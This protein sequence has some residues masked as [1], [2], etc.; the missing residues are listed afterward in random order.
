MARR[1]SRRLFCPFLLCALLAYAASARA[2]A[3]VLVS[4]VSRMTH[5]AAG[6]FDV[7][8]PLVADGTGSGIEC[9]LIDSG[10]T[11]V[12]T[13]NQDVAASAS[14]ATAVSINGSG[15]A[16]VAGAP[17]FSTTTVS[18][19]LTGLAN[20]QTY[21]V[22]ITNVSAAGGLLPS[23]TVW[24]RTLYGDANGSG[25]VSAMDVA[26]VH[27]QEGVP[28]SGMNFRCDLNLN[29]SINSTDTMICRLKNTNTIA[30]GGTQNNPPTIASIPDQSA[31]A[32]VATT[33][34]GFSVSDSE[35][36]AGGLVVQA[37]SSDA[38]ILPTA[39]IAVTGTGASRSIVVTPNA[40]VIGS[41]TVTVTVS[42]GLTSRSAA[43]NVNVTAPSTLYIATLAPEHGHPSSGTG[44]ALLQVSG[45][46]T[47]AILR[48]QYS[49]LTSPKVAEHIHFGGPNV[50]G[51]IVYDIDTPA[52]PSPP[53]PLPDGSHVW[54][55]DPNGIPTP[56]QIV[57]DIA[58]GN[59]YMNVHTANYPDGEIRGQFY[60]ANGSQT[61]TPPAYV[62]PPPQSPITLNDASRF[63]QQ[64]TF[65]PTLSELNALSSSQS[66]TP[67]T[68]WLNQQFAMPTTTIYDVYK[69]RV[70]NE[71]NSQSPDRV[72]ESW[73]KNSLTAPDQ[74]RQRVAFAYSQ[75]FVVS[76]LDDAISGQPAGLAT[77]H[78]M[79][80]TDAFINFRT[81]LKD[82]TLHPI[83]GQYLNMRGNKKQTP[84]AV[85]NE[86]Y[87]REI[88]QLFSIGL[89]NLQPDGTL[90]LDQNGL[91]I[92]SYDQSVITAFSQVFTG[93]DVIASGSVPAVDTFQALTAV[94]PPATYATV[95]S[96]YHQPMIVTASNHSGLVKNLLSYS[97]NYTPSSPDRFVIA[98]N[99]SQTTATANAE[100]DAALNNIFNH[101]NVGPFICRQLIQRLA[102]STPSPAYVYRVASVFNDDAY[103]GSGGVRGNMQ[104]VI[105]AILLDYEARSVTF[106]AYPQNPDPNA[107]GMPGYGKLREPLLRLSA[108]IRATRPTSNSG[109]F[110]LSS[111]NSA[112]GQAPYRA[113]TVFNFYT[114]DY[115]DPGVVA[116]AGLTSPELYIANEN[117][118]VQ[119]INTIYGGLYNN[120]GWTG[121][122]VT[123][124]V[125]AFE[126]LQI[127]NATT[128]A[129]S[130]LV[131]LPSTALLV[132]GEPVSGAGVSPNT[133]IQSIANSITITLSQPATADGSG[134][135]FTFGYVAV[136][137]VNLMTTA[138]STAAAVSSTA[139]LAIGQTI[140]SPNVAAGTY[141]AAI[142]GATTI[143]LS[144]SATVTAS[145]PNATFGYG[146][147]IAAV[148]NDVDLANVADVGAS[149]GTALN[150]LGLIDRLNV[151]YM[152]GAMPPAMKTRIVTYVNSLSKGTQSTNLAR[153]RAAHNLVL[154]SSQYATQK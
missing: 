88:L 53:Q 55:F 75:I 147:N 119:Y 26:Q 100:L 12:L 106:L 20:Q 24:F 72:L 145:D 62:P 117:T 9:R 112:L 91:P 101:P 89:N 121:A 135:P 154:S 71:L 153:A 79:L 78:D 115:S 48:F 93:W 133:T 56:Q 33:P 143:T 132:V 42:D 21:S 65:G 7:T 10:T 146:G 39:N 113:L 94:G 152:G 49:N 73:W 36:P 123:S 137:G 134:V 103:P 76:S 57:A 105:K 30:G 59:Y 99:S 127:L 2:A 68:D 16:P 118:N 41:A 125:D 97:G 126:P 104:A 151:L 4:A 140:I 8:L 150:Q 124:H 46:N 130:T 144:K 45:D 80:A 54:V 108:A 28:V 27:A 102:C 149:S 40:S 3:P 92:P 116:A 87:A 120:N 129:G 109:Y 18:I 66:N 11:L 111:T 138:A 142:P 17:T 128:T 31:T 67:L 22:T 141:V 63:L 95:K 13:F 29:G 64:A 107:K 60:V 84:P 70:F 44:T 61:F 25:S 69:T 47:K 1:P 83:M 114:P 52:P 148:T 35:T 110:K 77:W 23:A 6:T 82:V 38:S 37:K 136:T 34:V 131:S 50:D 15:G 43:F 81:L 74:L 90:K 96:Q 85:P 14:P 98:A 139:G 122:D 58:A 51:P 19:P 32:G 86:N 5:A